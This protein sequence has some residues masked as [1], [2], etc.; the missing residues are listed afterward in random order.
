MS[1]GSLEDAILLKDLL[2]ALER[3][4]NRFTW[5]VLNLCHFVSPLYQTVSRPHLATESERVSLSE[6]QI[7]R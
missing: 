1:A 6:K 5:L 3:D 2:E 7:L 4:F